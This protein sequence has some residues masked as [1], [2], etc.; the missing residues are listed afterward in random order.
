MEVKIKYKA[1]DGIE[2]D[3]PFICE[4]YEETLSEKYGTLGYVLKSLKTLYNETDYFVG[5]LFYRE[6]GVFST[7]ARTTI[8]FS[9]IYDGEFVTQAMMEA[10]QRVTTTVKDVITF[11]E[12]KDKSIPCGGSIV[13]ADNKEMKRYGAAEFNCDEVFHPNE[14]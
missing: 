12:K 3:D 10:E 4:K 6:N 13:V 1:K 2:F 5:V 8:D 14:K 11:F 9:D 7:F